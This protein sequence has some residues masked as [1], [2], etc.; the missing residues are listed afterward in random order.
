[1]TDERT[2]H[3]Q[4]DGERIHLFTYSHMFLNRTDVSELKEILLDLEPIFL[5]SHMMHG[6]RKVH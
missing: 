5:N 3:G 2:R 4:Q 1:M 6:D